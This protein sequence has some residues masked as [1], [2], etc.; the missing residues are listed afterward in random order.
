MP[1]LLQN[2][3][4]SAPGQYLD[5]TVDGHRKILI[6]LPGP[7]KELKALYDDAVKPKLAATLPPRFMARRQ[8]KMALIPEST[9]DRTHGADLQEVHRCGD[10][11]SWPVRARFSCTLS[12]LPPRRRLRRL[13]VDEVAALV[14]EEMG[15]DIFSSNGESLE[16]IVLLMLGLN[17]QKLA[18][19]ESC[20]GGMI[21]ER[22]T[23]VPSAS[24]TFV[25]GAIV[26]SNEE[27]TRLCGVSAELIA[28]KGAVSEEVA[29]AL[30]EG[31][32]EH[33]NVSLGLSVNWA[34]PAQ[35]RWMALMRASR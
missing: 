17:H 3:N 26:Y 19:A 10:D 34:L 32:R 23:S 11:D 27:K 2:K 29:R 14:E 28:E 21:A 22:L 13:R 4:G 33:C 24:R 12:P 20:T 15:E 31:I 18:V 7:P 1:V 35:R 5:T 30:A 8:L 9:V 16:E 25:G 6:L